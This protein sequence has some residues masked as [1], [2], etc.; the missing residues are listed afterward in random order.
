MW[1]KALHGVVLALEGNEGRVGRVERIQREDPKRRRTV[2]DDERV[3][4]LDRFEHAPEPSLA[5]L[6]ADQLDL[7]TDEVDVRRNDA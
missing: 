4:V 5:L 6:H 3:I 2:D 7:G 1:A